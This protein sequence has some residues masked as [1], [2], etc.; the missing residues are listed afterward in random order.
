MPCGHHAAGNKIFEISR[1]VG[2]PGTRSKMNGATRDPSLA[3][4]VASIVGTECC[5]VS[6][7]V[8]LID[9]LHRTARSGRRK[10]GLRRLYRHCTTVS[11]PSPTCVTCRP[12]ALREFMFYCFSAKADRLVCLT[13][14]K[15][16][17]INRSIMLCALLS[18]ERMFNERLTYVQTR[19]HSLI[20]PP[21]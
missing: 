1:V 20:F 13:M 21:A 6:S 8:Q 4:Y 9:L 2:L 7:L 5:R 11:L 16:L 12:L 18:I 15:A 17:L 3:R 19:P 14:H 10:P